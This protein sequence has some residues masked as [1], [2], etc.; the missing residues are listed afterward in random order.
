MLYCFKHPKYKG[1]TAPEI[2]CKTCCHIFITEIKS[3]RDEGRAYPSYKNSRFV[4]SDG[5]RKDLKKE[6]QKYSNL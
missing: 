4:M 5:I 3:C 1:R 6:A 2:G